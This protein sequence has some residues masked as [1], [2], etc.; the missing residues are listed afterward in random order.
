[1]GIRFTGISTPLFGANWEYSNKDNDS[2]EKHILEVKKKI[3]IFISSN[4]NKSYI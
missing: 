2:S 4:I 3:N 1:M